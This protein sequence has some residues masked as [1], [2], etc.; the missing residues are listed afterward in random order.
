MT[1]P[2]PIVRL[3]PAKRLIAISASLA[4]MLGTA[5]LLGF[6]YIA[7]SLH[8]FFAWG[9]TLGGLGASS[10]ED[11]HPP[12]WVDSPWATILTFIVVGLAILID[13]MAG[14]VVYRKMIR[15]RSK[16]N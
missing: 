8:F 9:G 5:A 16:S 3:T 13:L 1:D 11:F 14:I 12:A 10:T 4:A 7:V 6:I 15:R 2:Q